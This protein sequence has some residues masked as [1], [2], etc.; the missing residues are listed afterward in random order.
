[1]KPPPEEKRWAGPPG[2]AGHELSLLLAAPHFY[3][4]VIQPFCTHL[5]RLL[6][7]CRLIYNIHTWIINQNLG[8][9][10]RTRAYCVLRPQLIWP[11]VIDPRSFRCNKRHD[12]LLF[13]PPLDP[14]P[15]SPHLNECID[16]IQC[17]GTENDNKPARIRLQCIGIL[18]Y[19]RSIIRA[20]KA[21]LQPSIDMAYCS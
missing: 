2:A 18:Y 9:P 19:A 17:T 6:F 4:P 14:P 7:C 10:P 21:G 8:T 12:K 20:N 1:M 13:P 11:Q 3:P 5:D 15:A 16:C